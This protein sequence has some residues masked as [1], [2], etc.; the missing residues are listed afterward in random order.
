MSKHGSSVETAGKRDLS[1]K[2][3]PLEE[4]VSQQSVVDI[5]KKLWL[6]WRRLAAKSDAANDSPLAQVLS[7]ARNVEVGAD[8]TSIRKLLIEQQKRAAFRL[9]AL[10]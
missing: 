10:K 6:Q 4:T 7:F 2:A 5:R 1:V 8:A 3:K 9:F